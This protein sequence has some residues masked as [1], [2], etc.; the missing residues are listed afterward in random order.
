MILAD[1]GPIVAMIVRSDPYHEQAKRSFAAQRGPVIMT[2]ACL[3]ETLY[4]LG[5]MSGWR[6]QAILWNLVRAGAINVHASTRDAALRC[7]EYM[8]RFKDA[9]CDYADAS[10][11]AA[12]EETAARQVLTIDGH[13]HAYRLMDGTALEI[14]P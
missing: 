7:A 8:E 14:I 13:F 2:D 11:L 6:G 1:T 9:P 3:T 5:R 4:F 12:A 10:I